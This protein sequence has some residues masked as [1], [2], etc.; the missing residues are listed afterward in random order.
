LKALNVADINLNAEVPY[1][2]LDGRFT[3]NGK[4]ATIPLHPQ[5]IHEL[6]PLLAAAEALAAP[7]LAGK[8]PSMWTMKKHLKLSQIEHENE[9]GRA[10]FHSL[11]HTLATNLALKNVAPRVAQEILRHSDIRLT[12]DHYTDASQ[13]PLAEAIGS[14]PNFGPANNP[15][16]HPQSRDFLGDQQ[17]Q[18]DTKTQVLETS[19]VLYPEEF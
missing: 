15:Q 7:L 12:M 4:S 6:R 1:L 14:L 19:K 16:I 17:S 5:L 2:F 13:L 18:Q 8:L 3:K 10:D 9:H 11:R